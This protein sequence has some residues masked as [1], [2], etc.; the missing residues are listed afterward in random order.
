MGISVRAGRTSWLPEGPPIGGPTLVL[1]RYGGQL[2]LKGLH[3][4]DH[5]LSLSQ[6]DQNREAQEYVAA[7]VNAKHRGAIYEKLLGI[8]AALQGLTDRRFYPD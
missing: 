7:E 4:V 6:R 8:Q 2:G 3:A 5:F 1:W